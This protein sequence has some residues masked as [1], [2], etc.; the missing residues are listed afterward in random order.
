[1]H[2]SA[3]PSIFTIGHRFIADLFKG[4]VVIEEKIDGSQFSFGVYDGQ[5]V[6]R[7]RG[8]EINL[9]DPGMFGKA[10]TVVQSIKYNLTP[11]W[12]Y[13]GEYLQK[14]KHNC[15]AYERTP[16]GFIMI[17]D[18]MI[19]EDE[20]YL[21]P[22]NKRA[23]AHRIGLECVPCFYVGPGSDVVPM[24]LAD[25]FQRDSVLGGV[26][27]EGVVVKN[28]DQFGEDKRILIGKFVSPAFKEKHQTHYKTD[29]P[30][31]ADLEQHLIVEF[32]VEARW[33]KAVQHLREAGKITDT[34]T[35]IGLIMAEVKAD[36]LKEEGDQIKE[37]LF[38][39]TWPRIARGV[40]AGIPEWYKKDLGL[41][42]A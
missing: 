9:E 28:Y 33:R 26:K 16:S 23:E 11:G 31:K 6:C 29:A 4:K 14:P 19:S 32:A 41:L 13:R 27:I 7:S 21:C 15:L 8:Q 5:V 30:N 12:T 37:A 3:Y 24:S 36:I 17:F 22:E 34:P 25:Y 1:M 40:T 39:H 42:G 18:V 20:H 2:I 10:V 38:K 35:D